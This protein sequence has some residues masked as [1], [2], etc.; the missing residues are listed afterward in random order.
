MAK[1]R[2]EKNIAKELRKYAKDKK[3]PFLNSVHFYV[4]EGIVKARATNLEKGIVVPIEIEGELGVNYFNLPEKALSLFE[5][6]SELDISVKKK[7]TLKKEGKVKI[8]FTQV[9]GE[10]ELPLTPPSKLLSIPKDILIKS[11]KHIRD[12]KKKSEF[13]LDSYFIEKKGE[14]IRIFATDRV[15]M[16]VV[17]LEVEEEVGD[18]QIVVGG[19][20]KDLVETAKNIYGEKLGIGI[21]ENLFYLVDSGDGFCFTSIKEVPFFDFEKI[22]NAEYTELAK[23]RVS[24]LRE[25]I[26]DVS[27]IFDTSEDI[28]KVKFSAE[29]GEVKLSAETETG[30]AE[31]SVEASPAKDFQVFLDLNYLEKIV[32]A[33]EEEE[34]TV[35]SND[36]IMKVAEGDNVVYVVAL[37]LG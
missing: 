13:E 33:V 3:I 28:K 27:L 14:K 12:F 18:F 8:S 19:D 11:F 5:R 6:E 21:E 36:A 4:Q 16:S 29:G 30:D 1:M 25:A 7:V 24:S 31:V 26:K 2:I 35:F 10:L 22:L 37:L 17:E 34:V 15:A 23:I 20:F 9:E 32:N